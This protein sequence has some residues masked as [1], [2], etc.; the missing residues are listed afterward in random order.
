MPTFLS[1]CARQRPVRAGLGLALLLGCSD[2]EGP[3]PVEDDPA[4][5]SSI[6]APLVTGTA[7][8]E[9]SA[10][11]TFLPPLV[12]A[13]PTD[14]VFDPQADVTVE[15]RLIEPAD[16]TALANPVVAV[17]STAAAAAGAQIWVN[18][19]AKTYHANWQITPTIL[20][21]L[22]TYRISVSVAAETVGSLDVVVAGPGVVQS[23]ATGAAIAL[24]NG[25]TL[26]IK[27][28]LGLCASVRCKAL[29][30]CHDV[31]VCDPGTGQCSNP[32]KADGSACD[33]G[34]SCTQ[35]DGCEGGVCVG[36]Q[37]VVC[38]GVTQCHGLG[39]CDPG[40]GVCTYEEAPDDSPCDDGNTCT[41]QERCRA[42]SCVEAAKLDCDDGDPCTNDGCDAKL[43]CTHEALTE[44]CDP[45][46]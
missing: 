35:V 19:T 30:S 44:P 5:Y 7:S 10:G 2:A 37:P 27:F 34:D 28:W 6:E 46:Q 33:D 16:G 17:F 24:V 38:E 3:P 45:T 14:G 15:V 9:A 41:L 31:G 43:G 8:Q 4:H 32:S 29:D 1:N 18:V 20:G 26:P 36:G 12:P 22:G 42:G 11:F 23:K 39:A 25:D 13:G 21:E 40:T